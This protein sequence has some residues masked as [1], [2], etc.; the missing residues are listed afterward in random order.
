MQKTP[1]GRR[2]VFLDA[3][4]VLQLPTS[5]P[6][7]DL[8][9]TVGIPADEDALR[10]AHYRGMRAVDAGGDPT[11]VYRRYRQGYLESFGV[12]EAMLEQLAT[13]L[14]EVFDRVGAWRRPVPG[15][16]EALRALSSKP[17]ALVIVSNAEGTLA[18]R[19]AEE[20]ICQVGDGP[21]AR[22]AGILDSAVVGVEKPFPE[23][24]ELA[25]DIARAARDEAVHIGDS[26]HFDV[27]GARNAGIEG[28]HFDP[29]GLCFSDDHSHV[30]SLSEVAAVL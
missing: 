27:N 18:R 30:A 3:G 5:A 17:I 25:L 9:A 28:I 16:V 19:L 23:I 14:A 13:G 7:R 8:L 15:S 2:A 4:G 20:A 11:R 29:D 21:H 22:V 1:R 26:V 24:F 6:I 12:A 10:A